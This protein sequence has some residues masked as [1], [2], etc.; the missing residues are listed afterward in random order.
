MKRLLGRSSDYLPV[1][2]CLLA[3]FVLLLLPTGYEDAQIYQEAEHCRARVTACD[4]SSIIDTGLVR[5]GEQRCTLLL[6]SGRG[7]D[8]NQHAERFVGTG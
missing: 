7:G 6:L 3:I 2:V 5:A 8:G 4:D 1:L